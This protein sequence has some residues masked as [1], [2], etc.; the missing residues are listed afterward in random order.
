MIE[1]GISR[2]VQSDSAVAALCPRGG[3]YLV[4]LPK[5]APLPA[6]T[7]AFVSES[8]DYLL[9]K[10]SELTQRRLQVDCYGSIA[11]D[12]ITLADAVDQ[13]LDRFQGTL[14]DPDAT[15]V[16]RCFFDNLIDFF[17]EGRQSFRRVLEYQIWFYQQ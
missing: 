6:W 16:H 14:A 2:L 17:D 12:A 9:T 7:F 15:V 8:P 11:A 3:G 1:A 4:Q 10:R 13:V 5:D